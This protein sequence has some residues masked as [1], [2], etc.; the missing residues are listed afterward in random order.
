MSLSARRKRVFL[1][2]VSQG[3]GQQWLRLEDCTSELDL[4]VMLRC[5]FSP[6]A[7]REMEVEVQDNQRSKTAS[8]LEADRILMLCMMVILFTLTD[9]PS[10]DT[11]CIGS[12]ASPK[13]SNDSQH[14]KPSW[15]L[16]PTVIDVF[17]T[18]KAQ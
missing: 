5:G 2:G 3:E 17:L 12:T 15:V 8:E 9:F 4:F 13:D 7:E 16:S 1:P 14:T 11:N 10:H 18:S 6:T